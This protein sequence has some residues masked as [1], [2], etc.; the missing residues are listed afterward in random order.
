MARVV[1]MGTPEFAL[2]SLHALLMAQ[3]VVAVV[4]QP[5]RPAGRSKRV[6]QSPVKQ[7]SQDAGIPV[8][9]PK[10][11]RGDKSAISTLAAYHAD[12]FVVAAFGQILPQV[13][14]DLPDRG[15]VNVHA[16][17][18]PRWRGAAPIQAAIRAG[19]EQ[20]GATIM[21]LDAGLDTGPML[22]KREI[23][24]AADETG[25]TLHNKLATLGADLLADTLPSWLC[26]EITPQAQ[27]NSLATYAPQIKKQ[28]G[29]IDWSQ[30]ADE[31]ER[32]VRAYQ[33]WPRAYTHWQGARLTI[34]AGVVLNGQAL[35]GQV[36]Q[37]GNS[38]AI[39]TGDGLVLPALLQLPGKKRLPVDDF[40]NGYP[41]FIGAQLGK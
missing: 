28:D 20:S 1:F 5:D 12:V 38:I 9:Q 23:A 11:L 32:M 27:D 18:L 34:E 4:T 13:V 22:A 8:L 30:S 39:G 24:L 16:S 29:E 15:V 2:P 3:D 17:L 41:A 21:L 40:I 10:R 35:P 19:D 26:G 25:G 14:L 33:P 36:V 7:L 31:I 6:R 37:Q